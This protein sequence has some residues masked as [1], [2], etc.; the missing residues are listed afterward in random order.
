M[1]YRS[2]VAIVSIV[3][4]IQ[5]PDAA[6]AQSSAQWTRDR[7]AILISKDVGAER[8]AITRRL[9]DGR[10]TGNVFST[11]GRPTSFLDCT[12]TS[13]DGTTLRLDCYG[14]GPSPDEYAL[15]AAGL[16]L[17]VGFFFPDGERLAQLGD[18]VGTWRVEVATPGTVNPGVWTFRLSSMAGGELRGV[19][20]FGDVATVV[21]TPGAFRTFRLTQPLIGV[22][23]WFEFDMIGSDELVGETWGTFKDGA[24]R[25]T[26]TRGGGATGRTKN[27]TGYRE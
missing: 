25:C 11:D 17:P 21:A 18:L 23:G 26:A 7:D 9:S 5:A 14:A 13:N 4:G 15:I 19:N 16:E 22:C 24:G 3:L 10:V 6:L 20:Q 12:Q 27:F 8:W 2:L 1:S